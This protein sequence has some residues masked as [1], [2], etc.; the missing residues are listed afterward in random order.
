MKIV[1]ADPLTSVLRIDAGEEVIETVRAYCDDEEIT[2]AAIT[3]IGA[4]KHVTVSWYDLTRKVYEDKELDGQ[5]EIVSLNGNVSI[6]NG[7]AFV[8]VHGAFSDRSMSVQA[9][10]VKKLV[11]GATCELILT[12]IEGRMERES[13]EE[14]GLF[15]LCESGSEG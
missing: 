12:V 3:A 8:H 1:T 13:D 6:K 11:V 14:T 15:L 9:G 5:W 10:H 7:K 2:A 4:A